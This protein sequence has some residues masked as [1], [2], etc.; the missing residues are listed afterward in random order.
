MLEEDSYELYENGAPSSLVQLLSITKSVD[1]Y[2]NQLLNIIDHQSHSIRKREIAIADP[3]MNKIHDFQKSLDALEAE[4][5]DK[6]KGNETKCFIEAFYDKVNCT[7]GEMQE[8]SG[9]GEDKSRKKSKEHIDLLIRILKDKIGDL[10][11]IK[12][13][14]R[15]NRLNNVETGYDTDDEEAEDKNKVNHLDDN[16]DTNS[17]KMGHNLFLSNATSETDFNNSSAGGSSLETTTVVITNEIKGMF[18]SSFL[19]LFSDNN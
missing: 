7:K 11:S 3:I 8:T 14:L 5:R 4:I 10:K 1:D 6:S 18:F 13:H 2:K 15:L 12:K 17:T 19:L 16:R 9:G